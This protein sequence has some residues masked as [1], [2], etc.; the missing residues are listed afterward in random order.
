MRVCIVSKFP[1]IE[2]GIAARTYW[3]V[4]RLLDAGHDVAV[5]TNSGSIE[6]AYRIAGCEEHL[7]WLVRERGLRLHDVPGPVPWHIP[8]SPDYLERLLNELLSV[9]RS[10]EWDQLESGYLVP[11]GIA[12]HLASKLTGVPHLVRHGGSDIAKFLDH[13]GYSTILRDVLRDAQLVITDEDH[14][15]IISATGAKTECR[16]IYEIDETAFGAGER[17]VAGRPRVYAYVG[18]INHH[19]RRKGLDQIVDWYAGQDH[20]EVSLRLVGQGI[21]ESDFEQWMRGRLGFALPLEPFVPP[22]ETP[23]LLNSVDAVFALAADS[24]VRNTSLLAVEA[25]RM[26]VEVIESL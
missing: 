7:D 8:E 22:W 18:K 21:G 25:R 26:G 12:A 2:G 17:R 11:Y 13:P 3:H 16:P 23:R 1:P 20:S 9:L 5:V 4:R 14:E 24:T 6:A 15:P 10:G 19:W